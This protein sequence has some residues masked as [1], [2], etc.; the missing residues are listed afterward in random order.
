[1]MGPDNHRFMITFMLINIPM[2]LFYFFPAV[3]FAG[4]DGGVWTY[5]IGIIL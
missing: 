3:Y 4:I 5:P 2:F 1:M